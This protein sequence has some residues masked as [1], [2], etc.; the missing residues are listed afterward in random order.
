MLD[1]F[2]IFLNNDSISIK[3]MYLVINK[4]IYNEKMQINLLISIIHNVLSSG[5][6]V[7]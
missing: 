6:Q 1:I 4:M 3:S 5:E 7:N 2:N